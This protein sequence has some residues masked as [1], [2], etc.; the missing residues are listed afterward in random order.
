[1]SKKTSFTKFNYLNYSSPFKFVV[2]ISQHYPQ[3]GWVEHNPLDIYNDQLETFNK[4]VKE[5]RISAEN[6]AA[7]GI[8]NQRETTVVW[9]RDT[10]NPIYNAIVWLDKRTNKSS[11]K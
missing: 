4:A 5:S 2:K 11:K 1:M 8:T 9:N 7:I 3:S 10:G 6:I